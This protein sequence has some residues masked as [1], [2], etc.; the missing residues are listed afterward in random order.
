MKGDKFTIGIVTNPEGCVQGQDTDYPRPLA[1]RQFIQQASTPERHHL[2]L[3]SFAYVQYR[4]QS[5]PCTHPGRPRKRHLTAQDGG[6]T[7][8]RCSPTRFEFPRSAWRRL[9]SRA[10]MSA[11]PN[12][13]ID[14]VEIRCFNESASCS[15]C[16]DTYPRA[17]SKQS[18]SILDKPALLN[19][20]LINLERTFSIE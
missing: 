13:G 15:Y 16:S 17:V 1:W 19:H 14:V 5:L 3:P 4:F 9:G 8:V 6:Y 20:A 2:A 10:R 11:S 12:L 18:R 7:A